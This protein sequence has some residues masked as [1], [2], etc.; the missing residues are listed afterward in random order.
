MVV[1]VIVLLTEVKPNIRLIIIFLLMIQVL[2]QKTM[3]RWTQSSAGL[4]CWVLKLIHGLILISWCVLLLSLRGRL[5]LFIFLRYHYDLILMCSLTLFP[6]NINDNYIFT[7]SSRSKILLIKIVLPLFE[8]F[9]TFIH[10]VLDSLQVFFT[11]DN[12]VP[13][14]LILLN[15]LSQKVEFRHA[16]GI[17]CANAWPDEKHKVWK[18]NKVTMWGQGVNGD[19]LGATYDNDQIEEGPKEEF[20]EQIMWSL[21][22]LV[23]S[24]HITVENNDYQREYQSERVQFKISSSRCA[25]SHTLVVHASLEK[26]SKPCEKRWYCS[27]EIDACKS[28]M[29]IKLVSIYVRALNYFLDLVL[30]LRIIHP[31]STI[32][33]HKLGPVMSLIVI[34]VFI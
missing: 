6:I 24:S 7:E 34:Q 11:T 17:G 16:I 4:L 33:W 26:G 25:S 15:R 29:N 13:V 21:F 2:L 12:R 27:Q 32:I 19:L 5:Y 22:F 10:H 30:K 8:L 28:S 31:S 9:C 14:S 18:F 23:N 1:A 3:L 20:E